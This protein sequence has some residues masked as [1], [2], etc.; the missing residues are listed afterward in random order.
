M[1]RLRVTVNGVSYEVEVE[2]LEDNETE[3]YLP[4]YQPVQPAVTAT[5]VITAP[6]SKP[7]STVSTGDG[8]TAPMAGNITTIHFK[9]GDSV[10]AND[11]VVEMEAMK[12]ITK[13]N[14]PTDGV[15]KEIHVKNG[16]NVNQGDLLVSF[17]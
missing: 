7:R 15:I 16:A 6:I 9:V 11:V 10:K 8:I 4:Q 3:G 17:K 5:P 2:L 14:A 13:L 1:K 12:M